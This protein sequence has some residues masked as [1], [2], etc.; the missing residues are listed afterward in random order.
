ML[1]VFT[2]RSA[3]MSNTFWKG[4]APLT[5]TAA[6]MMVVLAGAAVGLAVDPRIVTGAPVWLKPAKFAISIAIYSLTLAW[7]FTLIPEWA[8]TR[9]IVGWTTTVVMMLEMAAIAVQ[10]FRGTASHFNVG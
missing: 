3:V 7:I 1:T 6:V 10:A 9:R 8:K 4:S 5:V 2:L